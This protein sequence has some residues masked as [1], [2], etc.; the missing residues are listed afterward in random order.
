[1]EGKRQGYAVEFVHN[2][3]KEV[4]TTCSVCQKVLFQPKMV[5]CCGVR[6]CAACLMVKGEYSYGRPL[7]PECGQPFNSMPDKQLERNLNDFDVRCIHRKKGC[8]WTGNLGS[9]S[10][11]LNENPKSEWDL[12]DGCSYQSVKC[13]R[14]KSPC[15]RSQMR[16]HLEELC[17]RRD[18]DC[19]YRSA[20]CD[21]RKPKPELEKH[22]KEAFVVHL[23]LVTDHLN[24]RISQQE[25]SIMRSTSQSM[26]STK[27]DL[28][29]ARDREIRYVQIQLNELKEKQNVFCVGVIVVAIFIVFSIIVVF[30]HFNEK[31]SKL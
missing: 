20:G 16:N 4:Q 13:T 24:K 10:K 2:P 1:M 28:E 30:G 21:V 27:R 29:A 3:P 31:L 7:C 15:Q 22:A 23:S 11:H 25:Q 26:Q 5:D 19:Y 17:S 9:L 8:W 12:Y 14:C 6:F 18:L